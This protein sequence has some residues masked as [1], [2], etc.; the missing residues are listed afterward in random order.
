MDLHGAGTNR[1][2]KRGGA[3][4]LGRRVFSPELDEVLYIARLPG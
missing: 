3:D 1:R 2:F 4:R